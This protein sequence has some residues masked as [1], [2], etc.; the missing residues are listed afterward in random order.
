MPFINKERPHGYYNVYRAI[1]IA[2][3]PYH[4]IQ[5]IAA[6]LGTFRMVIIYELRVVPKVATALP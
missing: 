2:L 3:I 5:D 1:P 6:I 4:K